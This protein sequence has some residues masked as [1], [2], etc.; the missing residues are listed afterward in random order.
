MTENRIKRTAITMAV[1]MTVLL[2]GCSRLTIYS[3]YKEPDNIVVIRT[4][5]ID[6]DNGKVSVT[7]CTGMGLD[8]EEPMTF[9][10]RGET[11]AE[12]V[13]DMKNGYM[14]QEPIF[15]HTEHIIIGSEAADRGIGSVLDYVARDVQMRMSTNIFILKDGTAEEAITKC[16]GKTSSA[17]DMLT[18]IKAEAPEAGEGYVFT[19]EDIMSAL[20]GKGCALIQA[21]SLVD[22]PE[23]SS[24][25]EEAKALVPDGFAVMREGY[26]ASYTNEMQTVGILYLIGEMK[27]M[28]MDVKDS[29][30]NTVTLLM[31]R[32]KMKFKP[33]ERDG[34]TVGA[35]ISCDI[36]LNVEEVGGPVQLYSDEER[37]ILEKRCG[38]LVLSQITAAIELSKSMN[39][40]FCGIGKKVEQNSPYLF[41][42]IGERWETDYTDMEIGV[43][44]HSK[45]ERTY[46]IGDNV[47]LTGDGNTS[48]AE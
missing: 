5:G 4:I 23:L 41:R 38:E 9:T 3:N 11:L 34:T 10:A 13:A 6:Y 30:E 17:S 1:I 47:N 46:D 8:G 25:N 35:D 43:T 15:S 22:S 36:T 20:A 2:S 33:L 18:S 12:A 37:R 44:V 21:V 40:D 42:E 28:M 26:P 19:G 32:E 39:I 14:R 7:C 29:E 16:T 48:G 31:T 24:E 27:S 45:I